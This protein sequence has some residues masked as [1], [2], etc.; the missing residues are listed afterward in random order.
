MRP[1]TE[2]GRGLDLEPPVLYTAPSEVAEGAQVIL[3]PIVE[4]RGQ[5]R[6]QRGRFA[7]VG[8]SGAAI[9]QAPAEVGPLM[10]EFRAMPPTANIAN[11]E[12]KGVGQPW[13]HSLG[14]DRK[15]MPQLDEGVR[16]QYLA[17]CK[18]RGIAVRNV[19]V[20]PADLLP[21]Q[22]EMSAKSVG[23]LYKAWETRQYREQNPIII[24]SDGYV[25]DGHHRWAML[26]GVQIAG[27]SRTT[28]NCIQIGLSA[29]VLLA[30]T[31]SW[32]AK[33]NVAVKQLGADTITGVDTPAKP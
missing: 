30:D 28:I 8:G 4:Y 21:I 7:A 11:L 23:K 5:P 27:R 13:D 24:S 9:V 14:E 16:G 3:G 22:G 33:H 20:P 12:V 26:V 25:L 15:N 19:K 2:L 17:N 10:D 6:D 31:R 29:K 18:R 32:T 1:W